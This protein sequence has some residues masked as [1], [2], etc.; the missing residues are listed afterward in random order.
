LQHEFS[1]Y[2]QSITECMKLHK[3]SSAW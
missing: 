2:E 3:L 1:R